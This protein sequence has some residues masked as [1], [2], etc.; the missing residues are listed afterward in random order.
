MKHAVSCARFGVRRRAQLNQTRLLLFVL[1]LYVC[2]LQHPIHCAETLA[3][4]GIC[5]S[6]LPTLVSCEGKEIIGG[7]GIVYYY[8]NIDVFQHYRLVSGLY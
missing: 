1:N 2:F 8:V 6:S 3:A 7:L 4:Y 5:G